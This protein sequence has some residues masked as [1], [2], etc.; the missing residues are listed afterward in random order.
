M[1]YGLILKKIWDLVLLSVNHTIEKLRCLFV[2]QQ[3][4][5]VYYS[6]LVVCYVFIQCVLIQ[7]GKSVRWI[8]IILQDVH[9]GNWIAWRLFYMSLNPTADR[10]A[11]WGLLNKRVSRTNWSK[12]KAWSSR[13][14]NIL[15]RMNEVSVHDACRKR[16]TAEKNVPASVRREGIKLHP[17]GRHLGHCHVNSTSNTSQMWEIYVSCMEKRSQKNL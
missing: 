16:Y 9:T 8:Q 17:S 14:Q 13:K 3:L 5:V 10:K 15:S 1:K 4:T 12:W 11:K 6:L 2:W 7:K